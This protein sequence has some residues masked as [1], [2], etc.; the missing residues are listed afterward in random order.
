MYRRRFIAATGTVASATMAGCLGDGNASSGWGDWF[1]GVD[2]YDGGV[3]A[4][5]KQQVTVKVGA[6]SDGL[7]FAPAAVK[8]TTGTTVKWRWVS[9]G[10]RHNVVHKGG[11][12][13]SDYHT[14]KG[15]TYTYTFESTGYYKYYCTPHRQGG[16]KG[17]VR[18]VE[19]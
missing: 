5:D 11:T 2:N 3:D 8:I 10:V 12:F 19:G 7:A 1:S 13:E 6:G 4:T 17:G 16:M 15:A 18:V 9:D 14:E